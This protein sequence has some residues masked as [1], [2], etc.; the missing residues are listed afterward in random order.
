MDVTLTQT[1]SLQ[2]PTSDMKLLKEL[3][4]KMGWVARKVKSESKESEL[5]KAILDVNNGNVKNFDSV[6]DMMK[7]LN[8]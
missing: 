1:V 8:A 4:K 6:S 3:A 2:I 7:Y 5:D